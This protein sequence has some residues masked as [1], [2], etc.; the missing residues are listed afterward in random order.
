MK[1]LRVIAKAPETD[2][3]DMTINNTLESLQRFVGGYIETVTFHLNIGTIVVI[4]NE[5]GRWNDLHYNCTINGCQFFGNIIICGVK[6]DE[7]YHV[8]MMAEDLI[9][10]RR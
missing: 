10:V 6:N 3:V 5:D 8:P 7:F 4:C 9:K 1:L 2:F